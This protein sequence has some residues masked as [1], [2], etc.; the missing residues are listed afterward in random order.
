MT[1]PSRHEIQ[2]DSPSLRASIAL[3]DALQFT[4]ERLYS[5][6]EARETEATADRVELQLLQQVHR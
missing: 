2:N 6:A 5:A 4:L 3:A 1:L